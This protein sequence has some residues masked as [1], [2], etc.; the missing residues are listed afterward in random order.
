M[1]HPA[2]NIAGRRVGPGSPAYIVAELSGNHNGDLGRAIETI[3]AAADSG[4]DAL[5]L[6]TYTADTL[7]IKCDGPDF[8]VGGTGPWAGMSL[9]DLY[10]VAHTPWEWHAQLFEVAASRALPI[11]STPFDATAVDFLRELGAP[12]FK[13]ASFELVDD[14]LLRA[15]AQTGKPIIVSTGMATLE[16]IAHAVAVL[17]AEGALE[18]LVLKCTSS[19][20]APDMSMNLATLSRLA[21]VTECPVGLSDHSLGSTAAVVSVTLGACFVEKHFTLS[22][23][24]GGVDSHF[25]LEPAEFRVLVDD[26]RRAEAMCGVPTFGRGISEEGSAVFRRSLYVVEDIAAGSPLTATNVRSIRP[27]FGM[28]PKHLDTVLGRRAVRDVARGTPLSWDAISDA[29]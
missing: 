3:H 15:V 18:L 1:Q 29:G 24:D 23:A 19:Y 21:Q 22:R 5:K 25:S 8:I 17:R 11:F 7:T 14:A 13:V 28:S 9:H 4:A 27:G 20:P 16:E 12:A 26:V 10:E 6:Q 2:I